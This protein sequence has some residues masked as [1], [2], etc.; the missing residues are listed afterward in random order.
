MKDITKYLLENKSL[1]IFRNGINNAYLLSV[2]NDLGEIENKEIEY[3]IAEKL[4]IDDIF[5]NYSESMEY[6][7][8]YQF[9]KPYIVIDKIVDEKGNIIIIGEQ[10]QKISL[11]IKK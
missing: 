10:S 5:I 11:K 4:Q 6:A 2:I 8:Q 7:C 9:I 3:Q 1:E